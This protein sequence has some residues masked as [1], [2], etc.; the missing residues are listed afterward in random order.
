MDAGGGSGGTEGGWGDE[1]ESFKWDLG[2]G[3][4]S[5]GE[6]AGEGVGG[7]L[8]SIWQIFTGDD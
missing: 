5:A 1:G 2:G 7:L 4:E 6:G 8:R 3:G